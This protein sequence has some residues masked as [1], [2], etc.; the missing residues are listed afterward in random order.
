V[1]GK[2][3]EITA[4]RPLLGG[5]DLAGVLVTADAMQPQREH[6]A[7]LASRGA[8]WL[9]VVQRNQPGLYGQLKALPWARVPV[10]DE[11]HDG[12]H[13]RYDRSTG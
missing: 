9:F 10:Q 5:M 12:G 7:W 1:D 3:N 4:L 11:S 6:A 2:S 13:G 8:G